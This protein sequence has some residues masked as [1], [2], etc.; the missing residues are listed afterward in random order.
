MFAVMIIIDTKKMWKNRHFKIIQ[1]GKVDK[2][3]IKDDT[4]F[5][6]V[7]WSLP[8]NYELAHPFLENTI[9]QHNVAKVNVDNSQ[10]I[11]KQHEIKFLD[12][13][14]Y[15][16]LAPRQNK[17]IYDI[18]AYEGYKKSFILNIILLIPFLSLYLWLL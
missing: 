8:H 2:V 5:Y 10:A 11:L 3:Y 4:L 9:Y 1:K 14:F 15:L 12:Q 16:Y 13:H 18:T 6:D 17:Y 7:S